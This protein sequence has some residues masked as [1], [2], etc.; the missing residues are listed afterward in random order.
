MS[1]REWLVQS[2][3]QV[4]LKRLEK[5]GLGGNTWQTLELLLDFLQQATF[6]KYD[7]SISEYVKVTVRAA[8]VDALTLGLHQSLFLIQSRQL[9]A[10]D[11]VTNRVPIA[12]TLDAFMVSAN[13]LPIKP[14]EALKVSRVS[15]DAVTQEILMLHAAEDTIE[16]YYRRQFDLVL[17]D[18]CEFYRA[19]LAASDLRLKF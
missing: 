9:G 14:E 19:L 7:L 2:Q 11:H 16:G 8:H 13:G 5:R 4:G 17:Q 6:H 12:M 3:L 18:A 1:L 15:A 10:V